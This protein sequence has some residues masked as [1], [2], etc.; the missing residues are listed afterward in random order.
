M[1]DDFAGATLEDQ[2]DALHAAAAQFPDL[3]LGRVAIRGWSY[4]GA[5]AAIAVIRRPDLFR[6][7]VS[8]AAPSMEVAWAG[9]RLERGLIARESSRRG[10]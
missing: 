2:I 3:D 7:A 1:R 6:A 4:G 5:L 10:C 8:A 9:R